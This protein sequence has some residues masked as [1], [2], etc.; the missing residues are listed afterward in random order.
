MIYPKPAFW[1]LVGF[2]AFTII[3]TLI[4]ELGHI[5]FAKAF[6]YKTHLG[7]GY[8]NY[9]DGPY[10]EEFEQIW[11]ENEEAIKTGQ[12]YAKKERR[13]ELLL[14]LSKHSLWITFA[15]AVPNVHTHPSD[16]ISC[17]VCA[18]VYPIFN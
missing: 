12:P 9:D 2:I 10:S 18:F 17:R 13:Q 1:I 15:H 5:A 4:H 11:I 8:M 3:G 14:I 6:G 16:P 7:Y